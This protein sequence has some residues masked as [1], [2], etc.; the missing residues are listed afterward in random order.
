[1]VAEYPELVV[2][3]KLGRHAFFKKNEEL[4]KANY[5]PFTVLPFI[6]NVFEKLL[7]VQLEGVFK[8]ILYD[9]ISSCK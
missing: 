1:M 5:R 9:F 8:G 3:L 4:S 2:W 6:N 7:S